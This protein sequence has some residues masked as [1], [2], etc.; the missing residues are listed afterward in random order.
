MSYRE[1]NSYPTAVSAALAGDNKGFEWLYQQT[2]REKYYI[3]LKYMKN[4]EDA[5]DVIQDSYIR[6]WEKLDTLDNAFKF[7]G[8][9]GMIV[10]NTAINALNKKRPMN[11]SQ[12]EGESDEG[13]VWEYDPEDAR[14]ENQPELAYTDA[15]RSAILKEMVDS[16]SDEQRMCVMMHYIEEIPIKD[17]AAQMNCSEGT[18]KSRLNYAR[19]N[20]RASAE[21]MEKKGYRFFGIAPMP[22]LLLLIKREA[23]AAGLKVGL[24]TV[25]AG[26]A[27]P[28]AAQVTGT[29]AKGGFLSTVG[30]KA[31][32]VALIG[33]VA[34][35]GGF[36]AHKFV[37]SRA[38]QEQVAEI[39]EIPEE[40]EEMA[41]PEPTPVPTAEPTPEATPTPT[42]EPTPEPDPTASAYRA[43]YDYAVNNEDHIADQKGAFPGILVNTDK[44]IAFRDFTEDE[45]PEMI[46][47]SGIGLEIISY[48][49][50][51]IR[52]LVSGKDSFWQTA[53][54]GNGGSDS[55]L[56]AKEGEDDL[57]V[58]YVLEAKMRETYYYVRFDRSTGLVS[59]EP[60]CGGD[61]RTPGPFYDYTYMESND[62]QISYTEYLNLRM[63]ISDGLIPLA[64]YTDYDEFSADINWDD[65]NSMNYE[66]AL[67]F[68]SG[69]I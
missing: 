6:A 55:V 68:L 34:A 32:L 49:N 10:A 58:L 21:A 31:A 51:Q 50:G 46:Y 16:L 17:I 66:E 67:A 62:H 19:K 65:M 52:T 24:S 47:V 25:P 39:S 26:N 69:Q 15:E 44:T 38:P 5:N 20:L 61:I 56:F 13:D 28:T 54:G 37:Q 27:A 53:F 2:Y 64:N 4:A 35:G 63:N 45:V 41:T 48:Q 9:L 1:I 7:P 60:R 23:Q 33:A 18:I 43:Y 12:L 36:A 11:F 22:L 30:G 14:I 40:Q 8:W 59:I 57:L 29:A 42:P 3:A